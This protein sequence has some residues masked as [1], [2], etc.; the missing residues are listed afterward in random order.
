MMTPLVWFSGAHSRYRQATK[1]KQK[2]RILVYNEQRGCGT[3][4]TCPYSISFQSW[5]KN[6]LGLYL[7]LDNGLSPIPFRLE[8]ISHF[9]RG[10]PWAFFSLS[11]ALLDYLMA[12]IQTQTVS[13]LEHVVHC[14]TDP[15]VW[16][17]RGDYQG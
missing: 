8:S 3:I 9:N 12:I 7:T 11:A 14:G 17:E 1:Q 10:S 5:E 16:R 6:F 13:L 15:P 2:G 4:T